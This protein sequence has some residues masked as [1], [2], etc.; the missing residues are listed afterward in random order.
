MTGPVPT[1]PNHASDDSSDVPRSSGTKERKTKKKEGAHVWPLTVLLITF[2]TTIL[3]SLLSEYFLRKFNVPLAL[4]FV[5]LIIIISI[6]SDI[7]GVAVTVASDKPFVSMSAK[8]V[9]GAKQSL[10]LI[11]SANKVSSICNDIFGDICGILSGA[12]GAVIVVKLLQGA[13]G[14]QDVALSVFISAII[15]CLTIGG[16]AAGKRLGMTHSREI[17][18][19]IGKAMSFVGYRG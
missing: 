17:V 16:K 15:A 6:V 12:A 2:P 4:L 10:A 9:R 14:W 19:I 7:A 11:R 13:E 3:F 5:L 18:E 8:K 1:R